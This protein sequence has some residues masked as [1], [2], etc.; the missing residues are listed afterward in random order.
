MGPY[1]EAAKMP[2]KPEPRTPKVWPFIK[3]VFTNYRGDV[4]KGWIGVFTV[5]GVAAG[6][7]AIC[8]PAVLG[9]RAETRA[10]E[11][12][13]AQQCRTVGRRCA[14]VTETNAGP[15]SWCAGGRGPVVLSA[16]GEMWRLEEPK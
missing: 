7:A 13:C 11:H 2:T 6:I 15:M 10:R 9:T 1:R 16:N 14:V 12:A 4:R 8:T 5:L 3:W